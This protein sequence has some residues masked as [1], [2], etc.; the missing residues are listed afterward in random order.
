MGNVNQI[1]PYG[2]LNYQQTGTYTHVDPLT[3]KSF[4]IPQY[5]ATQTLSKAQQALYNRQTQA[6][7][8][9]A[10]L[11]SDQSARLSGLLSKPMDV[12]GAPRNWTPKLETV[13]TGPNLKNTIPDAGHIQRSISETPRIQ[14][15]VANAGKIRNSFDSGGKITGTIKNAGKIT[16]EI[17]DAGKILSG[18]GD[19]GKITRSY[20]TD[21]SE[22]RQRVEDALMARMQPGLDQERDRLSAQLANQGIGLGSAAYDRAMQ[23]YNQQTN[24]ARMS[25]ILSGG[26]EQSRL[27]GLEANRAAFENSAQQ[28]AYSQLLG[29]ADFSNAAQAQRYG[30]NANDA[31]FANAAQAQQ[32]GQN[33]NDASFANAAQAQRFGQNQSLAEFANAAQAQRYGQNSNDMQMRNAAIGQMFDQNAARM[34]ARNA[35]QAQQFSQNA[36]STD[37]YNQALQ[38]EYANRVTGTQANNAMRQQQFSNRGDMRSS[39]LNEAY[40]ARNQ[41]INEISSLLG[42]GQVQSP[43]FMQTGGGQIAGTDYAGLVGQN[44]NQRLQAWQQNQSNSNSL[45]GGLFGLGSAGIMAFSDR[46]LKR[47]VRRVPGEIA[48]FPVYAFRYLWSDREQTGVMAQDVERTRPDAVIRIGGKLAV[49]YGLLAE[50]A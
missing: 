47:G 45:M 18:F 44:Y 30:Q 36:Q 35:A 3:G 38:G 41:P 25:A 9:L 32:Y 46:R 31:T 16:R 5:T 42:T 19:A 20:G 6:Q 34:Q 17:E 2:N 10:G 22:D 23:N 26:E 12:S 11:A 49:H 39:Y 27:V 28:Q 15:A 29:R 40:A 37:F 24:D 50:A 43:N 14:R 48:G 21:F 8:N 33:A 4:E 1:T 13:G 7:T